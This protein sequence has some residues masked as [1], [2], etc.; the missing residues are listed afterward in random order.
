MWGFVSNN[1]CL[2]GWWLILQTKLNLGCGS[3]QVII[4]SEFPLDVFINNIGERATQSI[5]KIW[6]SF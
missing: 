6:S 1:Y 2:I 3:H 5:K 4:Y